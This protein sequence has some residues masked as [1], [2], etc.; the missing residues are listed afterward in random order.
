M[1]TTL[2][3]STNDDHSLV[4]RYWLSAELFAIFARVKFRR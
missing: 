4:L 3:E 1:V 2:M